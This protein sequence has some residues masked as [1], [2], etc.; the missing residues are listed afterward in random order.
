MLTITLYTER[1]TGKIRGY[2][3]TPAGAG[4]ATSYPSRAALDDALQV[5][6]TF[7]QPHAV[8]LESTPL[9][10]LPSPHDPPSD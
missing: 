8:T 6:A 5:L 2:V 3:T 4:F 10:Y 9:A 1:R 7:G